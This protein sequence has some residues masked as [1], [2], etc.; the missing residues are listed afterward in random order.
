MSEHSNSTVFYDGSCPLCR[1]EISYYRRVDQGASL[2]FVDISEA[3]AQT[4]FGIDRSQAMERLHVQSA[5]GRALSGAAAF[6]EIWKRLPGWRRAARLATLPGAMTILEL[7]YRA[8]LPVRPYIS[9]FFGWLLR[10]QA[11]LGGTGRA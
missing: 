8:F 4:P 10:L 5:D 7:A 11:A 1:A 3:D 9:G 6:V 2:C